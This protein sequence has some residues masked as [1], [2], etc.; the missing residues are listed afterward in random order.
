MRG[1]APACCWRIRRLTLLGCA[2]ASFSKLLSC[3]LPAVN[4]AIA[5]LST[6]PSNSLRGWSGKRQMVGVSLVG[7]ASTQEASESIEA[8]EDAVDIASA[9]ETLKNLIAT[10]ASEFKD[11]LEAHNKA[12]E[13]VK[14]EGGSEKVGA[15]LEAESAGAREVELGSE[16]QEQRDKIVS[17]I[18][19]LA[20]LNPTAEPLAG[21]QGL[22]SMDPSE[23]GLNG[24]WKL[25]WTNAADAT[26]RMGKRGNATTFQVIDAAVGTFTNAVNFDGSSKLKAFRVVVAGEALNSKEVQLIFKRVVL[27]RRSRFPRF[28]GK[29]TIPLPNP[30]A[31][32]WLSRKLSRGKADQSSRGAGFCM[33]Y[34]DKDFRMH[35]TFDGLYFVQ[36]RLDAEPT[37][38]E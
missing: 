30:K 22:N 10:A 28:F 9:P 6:G 13:M 14:K 12:K 32:R 16:L 18:E 21:W 27:L 36:R 23:C 24:V 3:A 8:S 7:C 17:L 26:F 5:S 1:L 19:Q 11:L 38:A 35:R 20:D 2:L 25:L 29:I 15:L 31:L 4:F 37:L 33:L 34:L